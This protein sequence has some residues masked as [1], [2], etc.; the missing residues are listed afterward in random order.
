M[1]VK[2]GTHAKKLY[3][4]RRRRGRGVVG[5]GWWGEGGV[6]PFEKI[7]RMYYNLQRLVIRY[8]APLD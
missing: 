2:T 7:T 6:I 5:G 3:R 4:G 8:S 1:G